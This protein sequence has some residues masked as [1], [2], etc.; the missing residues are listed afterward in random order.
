[1]ANELNL[2][3]RITDYIKTYSLDGTLQSAL[4]G[5]I[6]AKKKISKEKKVISSQKRKYKPILDIYEEMKK[7]EKRA[8]LYEREN[9]P[10]YRKEFEQ[11]RELTRRLKD[12]YDKE[13]F[14]VARFLTECEER[15]IY[16][17][18]QL[19]ELSEEYREIK[20][21]ASQNGFRLEQSGSLVDTI[22]IF[23][24]KKDERQGI[25][26]ADVFYVAASSNS[27]FVIRVI[28]TPSIDDKGNI[29]EKY[30]LVVINKYGEIVEELEA[31]SNNRSFADELK[32]LESKY[33]LSD[34]RRFSNIQLAHTYIMNQEKEDI[35]RF[36]ENQ[37][38]VRQPISFTQALNYSSPNNKSFMIVDS[39]IPTY[40]AIVNE[41]GNKL[42]ITVFDKQN[43]IQESASIPLVSS[44]TKEGYKTIV[45]IQKKY[46]FSDDVFTFSS[47]SEAQKYMTT[48]NTAESE[49][50]QRVRNIRNA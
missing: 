45:D 10:E 1:M 20:K 9:V 36:H 8:Y 2:Q 43:K 33:D 17:H 31:K 15:L 49:N 38:I 16:A 22:G 21:Y 6:D 35:T 25:Y 40:I 30:E 23:E 28:K 5:I 14:E 48:I 46:G 13:V 19:H 37:E 11:Y 7:I 50:E 12:G 39:R 24:A 42:K 44:E 4:D 32:R 3:N 26:E 27:E 47:I 34:C 41:D 29:I 18:A